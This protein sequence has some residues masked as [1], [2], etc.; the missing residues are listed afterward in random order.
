MSIAAVRCCLG[1]ALLLAVSAALPQTVY[2]GPGGP[3]WGY[4]PYF[5][6]CAVYP[7]PDGRDLRRD[8]RRELR[9]EDLR[10][11]STTP[12]PSFALP[13]GNVPPTR[14]EEIRPEFQGSGQ[15]REEYRSSGDARQR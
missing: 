6:G 15:I 13:R 1:A 8:L 4:G 2:Y 7:C 14:P 12:A 11:Q 5:G 3:Y 10:Q 9:Q